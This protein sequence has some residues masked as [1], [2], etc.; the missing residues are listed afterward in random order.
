MWKNQR[1]QCVPNL[2]SRLTDDL[3][4]PCHELSLNFHLYQCSS[5][6]II[7]VHFH[8]ILQKIGE[9]WNVD[10]FFKTMEV[11]SVYRFLSVSTQV[12]FVNSDFFRQWNFEFF[13]YFLILQIKKNS[14]LHFITDICN[15]VTLLFICSIRIN[16]GSFK[17]LTKILSQLLFSFKLLKFFFELFIF[18][19]TSRTK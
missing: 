16:I 17:C 8:S 15:K 19:N 2:H 10:F 1:T 5:L 4:I 13:S 6:W 18:K 14:L 7:W 3:A 12:W 9:L 11:Y